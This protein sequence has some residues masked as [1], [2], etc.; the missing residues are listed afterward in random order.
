MSDIF[1]GEFAAAY[2]CKLWAQML[3]ADAYQQ[4]VEKGQGRDA[5]KKH[6]MR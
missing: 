3:A 1:S 4:F 2:Y 5:W 6:G